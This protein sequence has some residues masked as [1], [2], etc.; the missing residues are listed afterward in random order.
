MRKPQG[1]RVL[2][3]IGLIL[4]GRRRRRCPL[5]VARRA[6][7]ASRKSRTLR[8]GAFGLLSGQRPYPSFE[9][10]RHIGLLGINIAQRLRIG[11]RSG[12]GRCGVVEVRA[13]V[14]LGPPGARRSG[15]GRSEVL[16]ASPAPTPALAG[17]GGV[18][19][20]YLAA[21]GQEQCRKERCQG[22]D[23]QPDF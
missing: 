19:I 15:D 2:A 17:L 23:P 11:A 20:H 22:K 21:G 5:S 10:P 7:G 13:L 12:P 14:P 18:G 1:R 9:S 8:T 16:A 4:R 3:P 6:S